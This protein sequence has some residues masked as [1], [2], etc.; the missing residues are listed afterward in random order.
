MKTYTQLIEDIFVEGSRGYKR[1][2]RYKG[3][4]AERRL[5]DQIKRQ[6]HR[7]V[8]SIRD[9]ES[10][11]NRQDKLTAH[12]AKLKLPA[13][14]HPDPEVRANTRNIRQDM[15]TKRDDV[16]IQALDKQR[17]F[18]KFGDKL[19]TLQAKINKHKAFRKAKAIDA[20]N[21]YLDFDSNKFIDSPLFKFVPTPIKSLLFDKTATGTAK[22]AMLKIGHDSGIGLELVKRGLKLGSSIFQRKKTHDGKIYDMVLTMR[23]FYLRSIG[24]SDLK[25]TNLFS[26]EQIEWQKLYTGATQRMGGGYI[27]SEKEFMHDVA[28]KYMKDEKGTNDFEQAALDYLKKKFKD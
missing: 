12:R 1:T 6:T 23:S 18:D 25:A 2:L 13:M 11:G 16:A 7:A 8:K 22:F 14:R 4:D 21:E 9:I 17:G 10:L 5:E 20:K 15:K 27:K 28:V 3:P 19:S 24:M 26:M